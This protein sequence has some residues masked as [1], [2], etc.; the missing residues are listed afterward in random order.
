MAV[1]T[2]PSRERLHLYVRGCLDRAG[3]E[4]VELHLDECPACSREVETLDGLTP[5]PFPQGHVQPAEEPLSDEP[6]RQLVESV[7]AMRGR[8]GL[9]PTLQLPTQ[10]PAEEIGKGAVLGNYELLE[11]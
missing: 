10:P 4:A 9:A 5:T 2:C 6:F 3:H 1:C 7:K 11:P 8:P